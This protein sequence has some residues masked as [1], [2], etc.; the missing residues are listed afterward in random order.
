MK[1]IREI[2]KDDVLAAIIIAEELKSTI[3]APEVKVQESEKREA[4]VKT[5][6]CVTRV[7]RKADE[8]VWYEYEVLNVK[9]TGKLKE[10]SLITDSPDYRLVFVVDRHKF[11]DDTWSG[12]SELSQYI[13]HV[14]AF[15]DADGNYVLRIG[16]T[17]FNEHI[18]IRFSPST[19]ITVKQVVVVYEVCS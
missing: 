14:D 11:Y 10:F 7:I 12:L 13:N 5:V 17:G 6:P 1:V 3:P 4:K 18:L 19:T 16:E 15:Q 9:G 8:S 2:F